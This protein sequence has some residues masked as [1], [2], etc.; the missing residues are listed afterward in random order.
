MPEDESLKSLLEKLCS[1]EEQ[2]LAKLSA[3]LERQVAAHERI[4]KLQD[5]WQNWISASEENQKKARAYTKGQSIGAWLRTVMTLFM[6][7]V[8]A[9]A[10]IIAHYLK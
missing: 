8:I 10:I 1:L 2:Q 9:L 7:G 6:L 4:D 3:I 5:K